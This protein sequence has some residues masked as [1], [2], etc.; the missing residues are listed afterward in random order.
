MSEP[1]KLSEFNKKCEPRFIQLK[2]AARLGDERVEETKLVPCMC[3]CEYC[4]EQLAS[5][6]AHELFGIEWEG[7]VVQ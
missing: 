4:V 2:V 3:P 5:D 1:I 6:F 7:R